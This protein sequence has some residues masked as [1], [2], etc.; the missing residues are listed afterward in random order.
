[1][2]YITGYMRETMIERRDKKIREGEERIENIK[3]R[4]RVR[5]LDTC[6]NLSDQILSLKKDL[7]AISPLLATDRSLYCIDTE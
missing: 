2:P 1:M 5:K 7:F 6:G 4:E 3:E